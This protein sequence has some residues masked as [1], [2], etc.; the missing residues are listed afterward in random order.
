MS[1]LDAILEKLTA[2]AGAAD[3]GTAETASIER[4]I[5]LE[6]MRQAAQDRRDARERE[7]K[8]EERAEA[9]RGDQM[10]MILAL[11]TS[12]LP[13]I[14]KRETDPALMAIISATINK[15][16]SGEEMRSILEMQRQQSA[17]TM[18]LQLKSLLSVIATKDELNKKVLEDVMSRQD[19]EAE[20]GSS[21]VAG[22]MKEVRLGLSAVGG[23]LGG[24]GRG[25]E[26]QPPLALNPPNGAQPTQPAA[27]Q[28]QQHQQRHPVLVVL[29]Q[30][31]SLQEGKVSKPLVARAAMVTVALNDE[32]LIDALLSDDG[33][34][35]YAYC[36]PHVQRD[37]VLVSWLQAP[38]VADWLKQYLETQLVPQ[39][40]M[41]VNGL[42][43]E[44]DR[45][46]DMPATHAPTA[47]TAATPANQG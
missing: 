24:G 27:P 11:A 41:A 5:K 10:K 13:T 37:A 45:V 1:N 40:D 12:I 33:D 34:D 18:D 38:G 47:P 43:E 19:G 30:L 36:L 32:G 7:E 4:L 25:A 44:D 9:A 31:K 6:E 26:P 46:D 42:D 3:A 8:R 14:M 39:V 21:G 22:I 16:G 35:V 28:P 17:A 2:P 20:G 29:H 15:S 23:M